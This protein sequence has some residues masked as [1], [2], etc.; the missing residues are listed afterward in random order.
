MS[1][2]GFFVFAAKGRHILVTVL[3]AVHGLSAGEL[4]GQFVRGVNKNGKTLGAHPDIPAHELKRNEWNGLLG[5]SAV[6]ALR[7]FECHA[8]FM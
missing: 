5:A 1:M 4:S 8:Y 3:C 6:Q 7:S 2:K